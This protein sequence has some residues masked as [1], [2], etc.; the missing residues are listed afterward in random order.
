VRELEHARDA[1]ERPEGPMFLRN[2]EQDAVKFLDEHDDPGGVLA[3]VFVGQAIP[4]LTG[5]ETWVGQPSWTSD[6]QLRVGIAESLFSGAFGPAAAQQIVLDSGVRFLM[7]DCAHRR[8]ELSTA[9]RP[10]LVGAQRFG[11]AVVYEIRVA[12]TE[13]NG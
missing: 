12:G 6:Y 11:C 2:A 4:A 10:I 8:V 5:R 1:V 7:S 13:G 9:L 3:P